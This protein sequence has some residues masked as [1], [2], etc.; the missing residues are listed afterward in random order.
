[1]HLRLGLVN[2]ARSVPFS[3][4]WL[5]LK[6][7]VKIAMYLIV[8]F[9]GLLLFSVAFHERSTAGILVGA[10]LCVLGFLGFVALFGDH[11]WGTVTF[12][13]SLLIV[14]FGSG[15]LLLVPRPMARRPTELVP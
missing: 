11:R 5:A 4:M 6:P 13:L 10:A 9:C 7:F 12:V 15:A 3:R 2:W 1:S 14:V 8:I